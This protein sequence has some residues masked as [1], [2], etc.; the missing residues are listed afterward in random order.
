MSEERGRYKYIKKTTHNYKQFERSESICASNVTLISPAL[1]PSVN[2]SSR[3]TQSAGNLERQCSRGFPTGLA[4]VSVC[5]SRCKIALGCRRINA[6][7]LRRPIDVSKESNPVSRSGMGEHSGSRSSLG[8]EA[9]WVRFN[10]EPRSPLVQRGYFPSR[11]GHR[12]ET[13]DSS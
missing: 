11:R 1:K 13:N 12:P 4:R 6:R 3:A 8:D 5:D 2:L 10:I 7:G 9:P